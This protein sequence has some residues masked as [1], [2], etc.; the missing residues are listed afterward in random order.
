MK[1]KLCFSVVLAF[2]INVVFAGT[3]YVAPGGDNSGPGTESQPWLTI[4]H[5]ANVMTAGDMVYIKAGTYNEMVHQNINSGTNANYII[6]SAFPGDEGN[7]IIDGTDIMVPDYTGLFYIDNVDYI[8]VSGLSIRNSKEAGIMIDFST[9]ISINNCHMYN[10]HS[11]G[12]GVWN[13]SNIIVENNDIDHACMGNQGGAADIQECLTI[14][15][16]KDFEVKNNK[17]HDNTVNIL[18]GEGIDIKEACE[19]GK[20]YNNEVYDLMYDLGIYVDAWSSNCEN[21]EVYNNIVYNTSIGIALSSESGGVL[22]NI[23]VFNNLVYNNR[24]NG[25]VISNWDQNGLRKDINITNNTI[26]Q[27]GEPGSWGGGIF[28]ETANVQNIDIRNNICSDN[29]EW[30]IAV[31]TMNSIT[32]DYNLIDQFMGWN[33]PGE[34]EIKGTNFLEADPLFTD[35]ANKDFHLQVNSPCIDAGNFLNTPDFDFDYL[36]RPYDGDNNGSALFDIGA[37]EYGSNPF[38]IEDDRVKTSGIGQIYPNPCSGIIYLPIESLCNNELLVEL[39]DVHGHI[40]P[41]LKKD[42]Q[43]PSRLLFDLSDYSGGIYFM[44]I[45]YGNYIKVEK[46]IIR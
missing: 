27:N 10:T 26:Y 32:V 21:I 1:T 15:G 4:Q 38:D 40:F 2:V 14:S 12:I 22:Q 29:A 46:L 9:H 34:L 33:D 42:N 16:T 7:V 3:Y 43:G 36:I 23:D 6:F 24:E 8:K 39:I 5:A 37:H 13:C 44:R 25:I 18:G 41:L 28:I 31:N 35:A 45:K 20:V 17:V 30:Q 19:N 11:S